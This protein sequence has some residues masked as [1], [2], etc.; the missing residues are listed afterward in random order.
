MGNLGIAKAD[1]VFWAFNAAAVMTTLRPFV[2]MKGEFQMTSRKAVRIGAIAACVAFAFPGAVFAS[3]GKAGL[4]EITTTVNMP[5]MPQIS[6]AQ[7][8]QMQAMGV[9]IPMGGQTMTV[10]HCMTPQEVASD[11]P[12][13]PRNKACTFTSFTHIGN[14]FSG[15][16]VCHGEFEGQGHFSVTFDSDEHYSG[17]STTSGTT[18]GR[19]M[20]MSNNW[21]G[22][23]VSADCGGAK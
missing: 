17:T 22:R 12:P 10:R 16:E 8:A 18:N 20:N 11:S 3:H 5:N 15:D 1:A 21:E 6:A 19:S 23:W 2:R 4:W 14:T 9:H 13:P 7:M